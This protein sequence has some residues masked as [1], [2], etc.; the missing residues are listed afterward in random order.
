MRRYDKGGSTTTVNYSKNM[1]DIETLMQE[2]DPE[3]EDTLKSVRLPDETLDVDLRQQAKLMC[4]R[5]TW[6]MMPATSFLHIQDRFSCVK[7]YPMTWR[8][9]STWLLPRH[10]PHFKTID[11]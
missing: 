9:I 3:I 6:Q 1:P 11:Y 7:W 2:W 5:A 8:A 4:G 10:Y